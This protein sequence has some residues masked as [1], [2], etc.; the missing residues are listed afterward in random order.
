LPPIAWAGIILI[1]TSVPKVPG[2]NVVGI[3]KVSHLLAY[4]ILGVLLMRGFRY[5]Q[6]WS[7]RRAA[8][9]TLTIGAV[10]GALDEWHQSFIPGR[11]MDPLDFAAD[12]AGLVLAILAIWTWERLHPDAERGSRADCHRQD[13]CAQGDEHN[14]RGDAS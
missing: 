8:V 7:P 12:F 2:P 3:D 5:C 11:S 4:G 10:Y 1:G 6:C 9:W 13:A 14:G